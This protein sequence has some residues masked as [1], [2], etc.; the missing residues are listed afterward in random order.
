MILDGRTEADSAPDRYDVLIVGAGPAGM[1]LAFELE[2]NGLSIGLL[3]SGGEDFDA[4]TQM[5]YEGT[6][7]GHDEAVDLAA[8]RL[9]YLGGTTNHWGGRCVPM[10]RIDFER[11][12][13]SGVSGWPISYE[14]ILP[15][16]E[17]A[18]PYFGIGRFAYDP[19]EIGEIGRDDLL[20]PEAEEVR[21]VVVRQS[22]LQFGPEYE[23]DLARSED[24]HLWLWTNV[25]GLGIDETGRVRT[26]TTRSLDGVARSFSARIVVLACGAVENARQILVHNA[27]T[28]RSLGDQGGFLGR[29]YMDHPTAGAG[30]LWLAQPLPPQLYWDLPPDSDGTP[31]RLLWSLTEETLQR[32]ALANAQFY[33]IPFDEDRDPRIREVETGWRALRN[34]AKWTLGRGEHDFVFSEAYCSAINNADVMAAD[35]LGLIERDTQV[36]RILLKFE[37]EQRPERRN[38]V[39]LGTERDA[40]GQPRANLHWSPSDE[41]RDSILRTTAL[42]GQAAGAAGLGR[43]EFEDH[44]DKPY[45]GTVTSWHQMGTTRMAASPRDGV[46]DPDC[47][48]HGTTNLYLAGGSVMA[49]GSRANPTLTIVALAIRLAD[50]L[51]RRMAA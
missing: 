15:Y 27:Q 44:F 42:I 8:I 4:D 1:A 26:V 6:V 37:A 3:E 48:L 17:R 50:H 11:R 12:P 34:I 24:I 43:L 20:L 35:A 31:V 9:R 51:K 19:L 18:H 38:R 16:Y 14:E 32:E 2:G 25:T 13:L 28:G 41:D 39:S 33:L 47:K 29:C 49:T 5:L 10:D 21:T 45:W 30:F 7:T 22:E 46:V 23:G 40:L 36:G